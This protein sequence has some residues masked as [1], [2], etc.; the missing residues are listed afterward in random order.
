IVDEAAKPPA[1]DTLLW[2]RL[3]CG[4]PRALPD[5]AVADL[6]GAAAEAARADYG[7]VLEQLGP[8]TRNRAIRTS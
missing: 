5:E 4:L 7:Y 2:Y 8:C 1:R 6:D 3:A